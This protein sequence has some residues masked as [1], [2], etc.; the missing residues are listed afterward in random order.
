MPDCNKFQESGFESTLNAC[1]AF[2]TEFPIVSS[3]AET[4]PPTPFVARFVALVA[5]APTSRKSASTLAPSAEANTVIPFPSDER[6]SPPST[7]LLVFASTG[8][9]ESVVLRGERLGGDSSARPEVE[10]N[11]LD[12]ERSRSRWL[13]RK[14]E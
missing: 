13:N 11:A 5:V 8:A 10:Y 9:A 7:G 6:K 4:K 2:K 3:A 14:P 12:F 1:G